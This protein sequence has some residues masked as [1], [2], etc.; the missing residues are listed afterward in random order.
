MRRDEHLQR[1]G[2]ELV[3]RDLGVGFHG[4]EVFHD[5]CV[6]GN[7][8]RS[9]FEFFRFVGFLHHVGAPGCWVAAA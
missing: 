3:D 6:K 2:D 5:V 4:F 7:L 1:R 9:G 8:K